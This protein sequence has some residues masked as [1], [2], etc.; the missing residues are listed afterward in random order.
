MYGLFDLYS[1]FDAC[2]V[3]E[4]SRPLQ[5]FHSPDGPKQQT[6]LVQGFTN[7]MQEFQRRVKHG[8]RRISPEIADNF[9]DDCGL[10]GG[11]SRYNDEPIPENSNIRR[12]IFEYAQRLD[13]FLVLF[14]L[15]HDAQSVAQMLKT[16]DDVPNAPVLR[17]ISWIRL[18]DF[19]MKHVPATAFKLEDGLSRRK[20]SP[21]DQPYDEIDS[22]EF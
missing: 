14:R 2:Y 11:E 5:A 8:I 1:G 17:W 15:E 21:N 12:Y 18:F 13:V 3:G 4:R 22:E 7:S 9:A 6:T 19:E 10:K 20:P 16:V